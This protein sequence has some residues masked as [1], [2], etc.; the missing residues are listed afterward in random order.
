MNKEELRKEISKFVQE[1]MDGHEEDT[2]I[3]NEHG[4]Y[5]YSSGPA[6]LNL[7]SFFEDLLEDFIGEKIDEDYLFRLKSNFK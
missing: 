7:K 2:F 3:K 5:L 1:W 4:V 6:S